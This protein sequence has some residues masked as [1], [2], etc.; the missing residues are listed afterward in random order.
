MDK[1]CFM[2]EWLDADGVQGEELRATWCQLEITLNGT[3]IVQLWDQKVKSVR[4]T[5]H[6]PAYVL[7]EW[8]ADHYF[9]LFSEYPRSAESHGYAKRH[10]LRYNREGYLFPDIRFAPV[11]AAKIAILTRPIEYEAEEIA[12]LREKQY[13]CDTSSFRY[14]IEQF[15]RVVLQRLEDMSVSESYLHDRWAEIETSDSDEIEFMQITAALGRHYT[16]LTEHEEQRLLEVSGAI[17]PDIL[18][19]VAHHLTFTDYL[20]HLGSIQETYDELTTSAAK[21]PNLARIRRELQ[22]HVITEVRSWEYGYLVARVIRDLLDLKGP[23]S[24][25]MEKIDNWFS[26][27]EENRKISDRLASLTAII[28]TGAQKEV[29]FALAARA[30]QAGQ[31]FSYCR[32]IGSYFLRKS[33]GIG[34]VSPLE[35]WFQ[36]ANRAFAAEFLVP[37]EDLRARISSA[38]VTYGD[39]SSLAQEYNVSEMLIERQ[40]QNQTAINIID[41]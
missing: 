23:S 18:K 17:K 40:I 7:A 10:G 12:F 24:H 11:D 32:A 25:S 41:D 4:N 3:S 36:Q 27:H 33:D 16:E 14:G 29:S 2:T 19:A 1:L 15:I 26:I 20:T 21:L 9:F 30:N 31:V 38:Y 39:I 8:L 37:A 35:D 13:L 5:L 22:R 28:Y 34:V 6:F